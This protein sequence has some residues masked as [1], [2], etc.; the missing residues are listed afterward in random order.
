MRRQIKCCTTM[1]KSLALNLSQLHSHSTPE[2]PRIPSISYNSF[3]FFKLQ[4][5][6]V[7][8]FRCIIPEHKVPSFLSGL[9]LPFKLSVLDGSQNLCKLRTGA[10]AHRKKIVPGKKPF[11]TNLLR[12]RF[13][14]E[15]LRE[16]IRIQVPVAR[17][18]VQPVELQV[19]VKLR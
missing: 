4:L 2:T 9:D 14:Q 8:L 7:T 11:W 19:L 15:A 1:R 12:R 17:E 10:V 5:Q 18:A 6:F 16:L 3:I 13:V